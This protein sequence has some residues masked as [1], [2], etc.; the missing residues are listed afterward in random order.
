LLYVTETA[1]NRSPINIS[2]TN[3]KMSEWG[4]EPPSFR[5]LREA[6][7]LIKAEGVLQL[8][9]QGREV[10]RHSFKSLSQGLGEVHLQGVDGEDVRLRL[11]QG[12]VIGEILNEVSDPLYDLIFIGTRG[13]R[14]FRRHLLGN[15]AQDISLNAPCSVLV[16]KQLGKARAVLVGITGRDSSKEALRQGVALAQ[17]LNLSVKLLSIAIKPEQR[18]KA[19]QYLDQGLAMTEA[20]GVRAEGLLKEGEPGTTLMETAGDDHLLALGRTPMSLMQRVFLG[21]VSQKIL[22]K[23]KSSVLIAVP[24]RTHAESSE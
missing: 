19:Q 5:I 10:E 17:A 6:E 24:P 13:R 14:G 22:D 20:L 7:E 4:V 11:R 2:V 9:E 1:S 12:P 21:D 8:D 16:A 23:G 15:I 18:D 3:E